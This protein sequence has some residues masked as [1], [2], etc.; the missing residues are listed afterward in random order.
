MPRQNQKSRPITRAKVFIQKLPKTYKNDMNLLIFLDLTYYPGKHF[1]FYSLQ[2]QNFKNFVIFTYN[3]GK[4]FLILP[5]TRGHMYTWSPLGVAAP[6]LPLLLIILAAAKISETISRVQFSSYNRKKVI[7]IGQMSE[8]QLHGLLYCA[9]I[10]CSKLFAQVTLVSSAY[11]LL[12]CMF[13]TSL[14][15]IV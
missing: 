14:S 1:K 12:F 6:P 2:G 3:Q 8:K 7:F 11:Y 9:G 4:V 5:I 15:S 13:N 10:L